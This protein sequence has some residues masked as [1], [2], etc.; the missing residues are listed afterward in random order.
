FAFSQSNRLGRFFTPGGVPLLLLAA[1]ACVIGAIA[2]LIVAIA[3][4]KRKGSGRAIIAQYEPVPGLSAAVAAE[5]VGERS[6]AMTA[7][8]LDFAVRGNVRMVHDAHARV[9]GVQAL[10]SAGLSPVEI[11]LYDSVFGADAPVGEMVWIDGRSTRLGDAAKSLSSRAKS[12]AERAGLLVSAPKAP[13]KWTVTL[14]V[15]ALAFP[16]A[17]AIVT[18]NFMFMTVL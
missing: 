15:L 1:P 14:L 18:L 8:L 5:L 9:Y 11:E 13:I 4:R 3:S 12:E 7:S 2:M 17:H 6:R 16:V 10:T